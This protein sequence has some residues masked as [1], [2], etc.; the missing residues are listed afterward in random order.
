MSTHVLISI[1][2]VCPLLITFPPSGNML[3]NNVWA[4]FLC[5]SRRY[6]ASQSEF[7]RGIIYS[8]QALPLLNCQWS[9]FVKS[10]AHHF[11]LCIKA[12]QIDMRY[13]T[14]RRRGRVESQLVQLLVRELGLPE[15][16]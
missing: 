6:M 12:V 15:P 14:Q 7:S 1:F 8:Y 3:K 10:K 13:G 16:W 4:E 5:L 9:T 2:M 11:T